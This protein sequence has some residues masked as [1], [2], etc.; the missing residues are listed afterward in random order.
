[1]D[2]DRRIKQLS[3]Q[4]IASNS[5]EDAANLAREIGLALNRKMEELRGKA[6]AGPK[7]NPAASSGHLP[8]QSGNL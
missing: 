7:L 4:L 8:P 3:R 5:D 1:M 6:A 2:Y